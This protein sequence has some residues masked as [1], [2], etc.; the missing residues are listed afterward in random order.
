MRKLQV[1]IDNLRSH[2]QSV[3]RIHPQCFIFASTTAYGLLQVDRKG[4]QS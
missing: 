4:V 1:S 2:Q 3:A